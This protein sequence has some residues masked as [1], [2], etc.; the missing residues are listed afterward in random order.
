MFPEM[1]V[2]LAMLLGQLELPA[3]LQ[4]TAR[5]AGVSQGMA[6]LGGLGS[7]VICGFLQLR[8]CSSLK[9]PELQY[10]EQP[11]SHAFWGGLLPCQVRCRVTKGAEMVA[12]GGR[13][14]MV[15]DS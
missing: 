14:Q 7:T 2:A 11:L 8:N 5:A 9:A 1:G 4:C 12:G 10:D 6:A 13:E 15:R 3:A